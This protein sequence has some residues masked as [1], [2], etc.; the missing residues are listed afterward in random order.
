MVVACLITPD[1]QGRPV[2]QIRTLRTITS[3]RLARGDWLRAAGGTQIAMEATGVDWKPIHH[4]LDDA[5]VVV[6]VNAQHSKAVPGRK[7]EVRD[8]EWIAD[9]LPH[10]LLRGSVV[11]GTAQRELRDLTR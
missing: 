6:V 10:G 4:L 3:D 7:T 1:A 8:A 5:F 11:P 9:L 2:K